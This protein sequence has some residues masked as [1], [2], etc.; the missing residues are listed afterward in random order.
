MRKAVP[1]ALTLRRRR[2]RRLEARGHHGLTP[3]MALR[4]EQA[5]GGSA[6]AWMRM[7]IAYDLARA[8]ARASVAIAR[9]APKVA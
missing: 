4:L 9:L 2:S 8:R 5:F 1:V 6:D 7:Q 3:E